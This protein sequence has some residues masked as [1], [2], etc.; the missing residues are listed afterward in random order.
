MNATASRF[1][2]LVLVLVSVLLWVAQQTSAA[3]GATSDSFFKGK[4]IRIVVGYAPGGGFDT[5]ARLLA[6]HLG[7]HVPGK[8]SVIVQNMP[9]AG[10]LVAANRVYVTQPGDGLTIA[11]FHFGKV[12]QALVDPVVQFDPLKYLWLGDP[13]IGGLPSVL[14]VRNDV[15]IHSLADLKKRKE[16]LIVGNTGVGTGPAVAG[17]FMRLI[18]L[19]VKSVYGY[20]GSRAVMA[21][22]ER[23]EVDG[24]IISQATMQ[25]IY[26]RF[27]EN[28]FVRPIL[29][30]GN[31]PRLKP[32]PGIAT[33]KDLNLSSAQRK[34]AD[35]LVKTW[36]LLRV[37]ALPPGTP[38]QRTKI[39]R[40]AFLET[41]KSPKLIK[42]AER[43]RVTIE[44]LSGEEVTEI[45]RDMF[46]ASPEILE[47]YKKLILPKR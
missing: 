15:P 16:P 27:V 18:G 37:F 40:E 20:E 36:A 21:A 28:G 22:L 14:W 34:L 5:F 23:K 4:M 35:F 30:L 47:E 25:Q 9:G 32:I 26:R 3:S 24:R 33:M 19:P 41:L 13:T 29:A 45:I 2:R 39:L 10:S 31:E 11:A 38:P 43:Q 44:P 17:E 7:D 12:S 1:T 6:R 46:Q 8:P 42:D